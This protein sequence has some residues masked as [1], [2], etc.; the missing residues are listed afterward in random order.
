MVWVPVAPTTPT[1]DLMP[2][3]SRDA[4]ARLRDRLSRSLDSRYRVV[5]LLGVGGMGVV[6]LADDLEHDRQVAIKVLPPELTDDDIVVARFHREA[7][8]AASL[9]HP[10]I[11]RVYSEGSAGG[12][13]YFVM[14]YVPGRSLEQLLR[15]QPVASIAFA[16]RILREASAALAHAHLCNVVHRDVKP[17][18]IMLDPDGR[19]VL[20]DFGI[21]K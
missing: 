20:T 7:K 8:T 1:A 6:F 2:S 10:G 19:V 13:H 18:N 3:V 14:Q 5:D 17:E 11:V 4:P 9:D 12:L 16:T 15:E 21:S